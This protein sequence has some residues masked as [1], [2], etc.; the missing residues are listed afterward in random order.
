MKMNKLAIAISTCLYSSL[1]FQAAIADD[2]EI[3]VPK[4]LPADQQV[5][6]NIMFVLDSSGSMRSE[7]AN[8]GGQSRNQ[9]MRS[10]VKNLI[11]ELK[12]K[13]DV[14]VGIMR[15]RGS[16][17]GYLL[18]ESSRLTNA[19]ATALKNTVDTVPASGS[20][21][22]A[23]TF[24]ESYRYF[25]GQAPVWGAG[26]SVASS[27]SGGSY[28]S[29]I[30]H[31]CQQSHIIYITDGVPYSD[32][33][34]NTA[35]NNLVSNKNTT[36]TSCNTGT[37]GACLPHLAEYM[38]NQDLFPNP[39]FSDPTQRKQTVTSH[40]IGFAIDL[41]LLQNAAAAGGGKY[42]TSD[43]VS[44]LTDALKAIVT[45]IT[46][47]NT[48]FTAP[49][50]AVSAFNN[51]GYRDDLYYALF[52]PAEGARWPGNVK[53]YKLATDSNGARVIVDKNGNNAIDA[54]TGF[55]NDNASS[56][57]STLDGKDIAKGGVAALLTSPNSRNIF[58][59]SGTEP[60]P[61]ASSGVTG[62]TSLAT[63]ASLDSNA[64]NSLFGASNN[65]TRKNYV[66]WA[67]GI[68]PDG[69]NRLA[70]GDVL[71]SEPLLVAYKVD[72]YLNR[73]AETSAPSKEKLYMFFGTNEGY[74]HAVDPANGSE[75]FAIIPKDLLKNPGAYYENRT[76]S[77]N[78]TYGLDG[79]ITIAADYTGTDTAEYL[80]DRT[81]TLTKANLYVGMRRGGSNYYAFDLANID[82]P[83]LKWVIKGPQQNKQADGSF[84]NNTAA[85]TPG[86]EK[87]GNT[88][89]AAKVAQIKIASGSTST[90]QQV[91]V[92]TGGYD[93][94]QDKIGTNVPKNDDVGNSLYIVNADTGK[95]I[96]RAGNTG[97]STASLQVAN[98]TNS[99]A[100][101]PTLVDIDGDGLLDI[102]YA[103]DMRGQVFRFDIN[104]TGTG[105]TFD[106]ARIA[107]LGGVDAAHN[108]RFFTSPDVA[109][110]RER[111]GDT[112]FTISIGSGFRESPLNTDTNDRFYVLRD[113]FVN[114]KPSTAA[115]STYPNITENDLVDVS[116]V[117][118]SDAQAATVLADIKVKE[119]A[120]TALNNALATARANLDAY[121]VS[122][123]FQAKQDAANLNKTLAND[124]QRSMDDIA[125]TQP[126]IAQ[127]A[128]NTKA[129]SDYQAL[130][131]DTHAA[132]QG[133]EAAYQAA[134]ALDDSADSAVLTTAAT[135]AQGDLTTATNNYDAA[136]LISDADAA[137]FASKD[138]TATNAETAATDAEALAA[139]K[140]TEQQTA[141]QNYDNAVLDVPIKTAAKDAADGAHATALANQGNAVTAQ[142][143]A[144]TAKNNA[145]SDLSNKTLARD[146]AQT[147]L[148]TAIAALA[149][150]PTDPTLI[151]AKD[152]AQATF[153]T[154]VVAYDAAV[155]VRDNAATA[156]GTAN[157]DLTAANTAL[158]DAAAAQTAA[159]SA[160][161]AANN[162]VTSTNSALATANTAL[163]NA[164]T[165][166]TT[167]RS[168]ATTDRGI[169]NTAQGVAIASAATTATK[170][171]LK[172]DAQTA[173]DNAVAARDK[174]VTDDA[175]AAAMLS[176]RDKLALEL[177][178][179][180][181]LRD[182]A[183]ANWKVVTDLE[184]A[185]IAAKN[186]PSFDSDLI[187]GME[188]DLSTARATYAAEQAVTDRAAINGNST[189][190]Q[191]LLAQINTALSAGATGP[192]AT[193]IAAALATPL[194]DLKA[195]LGF[196]GTATKTAAE[197][198]AIDEATKATDL[199]DLAT[200]QASVVATLIQ[201]ATD[202][203][204]YLTLATG[205]QTDA[206]AIAAV[207][208][209]GSLLTSQ[210]LTDA[211]AAVAPEALTMFAAYQYL[212]DLAI[213]NAED[214][215]T[216]LPALRT[217]INNLYTQLTPG[218]SYTPN[219]ALLKASKGF[220]LRL[221]KGEKVL[222]TSVSFGGAVL[223]TT[224]SPRGQTTSTCGSDVGVGRLY[225]MSLRDASAV[226]T[227]TING[228]KTPV[229]SFDLTRSGIPPSPAVVLGQDKPAIIVGSESLDLPCVDANN[230]LCSNQSAADPLYW[231][232]N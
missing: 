77:S 5:R 225:A 49:S 76:G 132:L 37:D 154:A 203:D 66:K 60:S 25:S 107:Q 14:N 96:W 22:M 224:F 150:N 124:K 166:A 41:P 75:K 171:Q 145:D 207:L 136:K 81:R 153:D 164:N 15:F 223:F 129:Q 67:K 206:D 120:M 103:S 92:F 82:N 170:L 20:T 33:G 39:S 42:Y 131:R 91:L 200:N 133:V 26:H 118:L 28:K 68:N 173:Y 181:A 193:A 231:R 46:A 9:V 205:Y 18:K 163:T 178:S 143:S 156:L 139:T 40:F 190:I 228:T 69:T 63:L 152:S 211:T 189:S 70:I 151:A 45:D 191:A 208:Y 195:A 196:S 165:A 201:L 29:P 27:I 30:E 12:A 101:D 17:G 130:I 135:T 62:T 109:L 10:V 53:R 192:D 100:A 160:L 167:A 148:N 226:F 182:A 128:P 123:G 199:G 59:W 78:K 83:R 144:V 140:L 229:R 122:S 111:G 213:R 11:D 105:S 185:L 90:T 155:I 146:T 222:S 184:D 3:Y 102:I 99:M 85:A 147:N 113:P 227:Q 176:L 36:Y 220:Y 106:G 93:L 57:W 168:Q 43:N 74:L 94:D 215:V 1:S 202:R 2:T 180:T 210:Q 108:R 188:A 119:D 175:A 204:A 137:D 54:S 8:T 198:L 157:S 212:V 138:T 232:E 218:N 6:P 125:S 169:A 126:Y 21:P 161:T 217:Q 34:S 177:E 80:A 71:H 162:L 65:A 7:V 183:D 110:I 24:Y 50:V 179:M 121:K 55:F 13:E 23:E 73:E 4:D 31:S 19:N 86:F 214:P 32:T 114:T 159:N 116:S 115:P 197:L 97:D 87:L 141:Q 51:L 16:N 149:G 194:A 44:G 58:T 38:H 219:T 52:R 117:N 174:A 72:D 95:L 127:H 221:P 47:A 98:M 79:K 142:G 209:S 88:F 134:K 104:N 89:S 35:I 216:G 64:N 84:T 48:T 61:T 187:P 172:T 186:D 230:P 56:Y 158:T 112:Y